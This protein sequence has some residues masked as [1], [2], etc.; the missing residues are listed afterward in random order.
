M[1]GKKLDIYKLQIITIISG[2]WIVVNTNVCV[3]QATN[4][5]V[6]QS[7]HACWKVY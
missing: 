3:H 7:G 1:Y 5:L 4:I 2:T 6:L